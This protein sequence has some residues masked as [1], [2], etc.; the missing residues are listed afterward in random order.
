MSPFHTADMRLEYEVGGKRY[1]HD[2]ET[3]SVDELDVT[4]P[5]DMPILWADPANPTRVERH[6]PGFWMIALLVVGFAASAIYSYLLLTAFVLQYARLPRRMI[7][8]REVIERLRRIATA[9]EARGLLDDVAVLGGLVVTHDSIA[10]GVHF[11]PARPAG[12]RRLEAGRGKSLRPR[13]ERRDARRSVAVADDQRP[14]RVGGWLSSSGVEAACESYGVPLLGGDTIALARRRAARA[15]V[16]GDRPRRRR[17]TRQRRR[18]AGRRPVA[19][20]DSRRCRGRARSAA[21][22]P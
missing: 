21:T 13:R 8:E 16:D 1:Q 11:L 9:P 7:R 14:G 6:G 12:K 17:R 4:A 22:G 20:R 3:H 2:I 15:W 18:Q 5:D 19:G 10:E